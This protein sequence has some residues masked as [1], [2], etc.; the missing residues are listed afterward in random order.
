MT[1]REIYEILLKEAGVMPKTEIEA[2]LW[3]ND[4]YEKGSP[5]VQKALIELLALNVV[6]PKDNDEKIMW[7]F[8]KV[9][10]ENKNSKNFPTIKKEL[11]VLYYEGYGNDKTREE[12]VKY[13]KNDAEKEDLESLIFMGHIHSGGFGVEKNNEIAHNWYY[14]AAQKND[15]GAIMAVGDYFYHKEEY[16]SAHDWYLKA[17]EKG[18]NSASLRLSLLYKL[19]LG[20]D[21]S[22][23][24]SEH[25]KNKVL[26]ARKKNLTK[27]ENKKKSKIRVYKQKTRKHEK[28]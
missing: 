6:K 9:L 19:G 4:V 5:V 21:A 17:S 20:V 7:I 2:Q 26:K 13:I 24:K 28:R 1:A 14:K 25:Y 16:K 11:R 18:H 23:E 22:K 15:S 10:H 3:F 8:R 27:S 12:I